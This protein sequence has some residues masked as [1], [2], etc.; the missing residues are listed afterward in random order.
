MNRVLALCFGACATLI[1]NGDSPPR[2]PSSETNATRTAAPILER[3]AFVDP[4]TGRIV[5][6]PPPGVAAVLPPEAQN[7][8]STS[9]E[10]L[11]EEPG[12]TRSGGVKVHLQGRFRSA[13][14]ATIGADGRLT[15]HCRDQAEVSSPAR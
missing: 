5:G 6:K 8:L 4:A 10:G 13:V 3:K 11:R 9:G 1:L 2:S 14:T 15:T 7:A 12:Q